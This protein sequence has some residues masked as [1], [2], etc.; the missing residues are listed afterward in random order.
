MKKQSLLITVTLFLTSL[1][2]Y[3]QDNAFITVW[4]VG[5]D[6]V[7]DGDLTIT[8]PT[9][10]DGYNYTVDWGDEGVESGFTANAAH[11]Y[12]APGKYT[13]K[14]YGDFPGIF[15]N[16]SSSSDKEKIQTITQWGDI[17]WQSMAG[18]FYGM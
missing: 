10:G 16:N 3:G 8:I 9:T 12:D 13:I 6:S 18:A 7:G 5:Q 14:I 4:R 11:R 1:T 17:G 2:G 15:F